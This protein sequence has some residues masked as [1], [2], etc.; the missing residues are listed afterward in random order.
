MK[1]PV[2]DGRWQPREAIVSFLRI[3][4]QSPLDESGLSDL[5]DPIVVL[6]LTERRR[7]V[8]TLLLPLKDIAFIIFINFL[9]FTLADP[10]ARAKVTGGRIAIVD[11]LNQFA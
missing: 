10:Y 2:L 3:D 8:R 7:I 5:R 9:D 4:S 11:L 6:S 1:T